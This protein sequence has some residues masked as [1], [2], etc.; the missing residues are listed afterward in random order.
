MFA[1]DLLIHLGQA[2]S[3]RLFGSSI[4]SECEFEEV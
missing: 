2:I 3:T 1:S 4:Q